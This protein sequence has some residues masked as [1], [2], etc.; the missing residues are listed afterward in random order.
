MDDRAEFRFA[1]ISAGRYYLYAKPENPFENERRLPHQTPPAE[2]AVITYYPNSLE[3]RDAVPILLTTGQQIT[4]LE[5]RLR[6]VTV[7]SVKGRV[8]GWEKSLK[9]GLFPSGERSATLVP[10]GNLAPLDIANAAGINKDG[11]FELVAVAPGSYELKIWQGSTALAQ[12]TVEVGDHDVTGIALQ[13]MPVQ[14]VSGTLRGEGSRH[15]D[16]AGVGVALQKESG[17]VWSDV[18]TTK[19]DGNFEISNLHADRYQIRLFNEPPST[20][21]KA[22][23]VGGAEAGDGV[24]DLTAGSHGRVEVVLSSDSGQIEGDVRFSDSEIP[25]PENKQQTVIAQS[26]KVVLVPHSASAAVQE[27]RTKTAIIDQNGGFNLEGIAPGEYKLY[28][29]EKVQEE[30]WSDSQFLQQME[31]DA[32]KV[33]LQTRESKKV[34]LPLIPATRIEEVMTRLGFQ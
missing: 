19:E 6:Q 2:T 13:I 28:A 4:D 12:T 20:Y 9:P 33:S 18:V 34:H 27:W 8:T 22:V 21:L 23:Y 1:G 11:T 31:S 14:S 30:A 15:F 5:I 25:K 7:H 24:V 16:L 32:V 26:W 3:P 17:D 29:F 10:E